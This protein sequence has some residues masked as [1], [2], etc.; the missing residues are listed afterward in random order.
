[1]VVINQ[2]DVGEY[3][4]SEDDIWWYEVNQFN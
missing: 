1:V 3:L 4:R 2:A